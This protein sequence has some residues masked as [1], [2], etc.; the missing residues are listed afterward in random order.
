L[1]SSVNIQG[2]H[3]SNDDVNRDCITQVWDEKLNHI[4]GR[5]IWWDGTR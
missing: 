4:F 3:V 1:Y 2:D 5:K